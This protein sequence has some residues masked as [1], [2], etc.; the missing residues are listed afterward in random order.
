MLSQ[1][2][3]LRI[4]GQ[5]AADRHVSVSSQSVQSTL[6]DDAQEAGGLKTLQSSAASQGVPIDL[7]RP[8]LLAGAQI[9][10]IG[11]ALLA[12]APISQSALQAAYDKNLSQYEQAHVA[13]ILVKSKS[14]AKHL[15]AEVTAHPSRFGA[16]AKQYS[17]DTG[18]AAKGGDLGNVGKGQT[19]PP[20]DKAIFSDPV[21]S[22]VFFF[23][24]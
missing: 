15:L 23:Y 7:I 14:L 19:V 6:D 4:I 1:L 8:E 17:T 12:N 2:I 11:D 24:D 20:F 13:H 9:T 10:A 21:G 16:L 5:E 18:S 3:Q 22:Y